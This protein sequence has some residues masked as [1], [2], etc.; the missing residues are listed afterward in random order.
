M[1]VDSSNSNL[2]T[3]KG[4]VQGARQG[5]GSTAA[6]ST[7]ASGAPAPST[8]GQNGGDASVNLSALSAQMR[9]LAASGSADIDVAHVE[10]I[11]AAIRNGS[12]SIDAGK[13][14]DGIL[15]TARELLQ[16]NSSGS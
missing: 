3:P 16:K 10:S 4:G 1:K 9:S 8:A 12:L 5:A 7:G 15:A 14:A 11:K 6:A 2:S 13:I